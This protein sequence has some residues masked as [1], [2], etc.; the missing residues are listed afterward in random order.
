MDRL[1]VGQ[2][3][4]AEDAGGIFAWAR[5]LA[6]EADATI[7]LLLA[8]ERGGNDLGAPSRIDIGTLWEYLFLEVLRRLHTVAPLEMNAS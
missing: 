2:R 4:N 8:T 6:P 5:D 1:T 7:R 3:H